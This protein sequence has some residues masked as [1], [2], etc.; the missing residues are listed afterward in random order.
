MR[1]CFLLAL[2]F[3]LTVGV[4]AR[5]A[6]GENCGLTSL[7]AD[8]RIAAC[9]Q[10]IA[11]GQG[12]TR[13]MVEALT[14]RAFL[15]RI[16]GDYDQAIADLTEAL[17]LSP[18][19]AMAY[20]YRGLSWNS[21]GDH[22]RAIADYTEAI[23]I[24]ANYAQAYVN[25]GAARSGKGDYDGAIADHSEA[26]RLNPP[27][28]GAYVARAYAWTHKGDKDKAIA[29][30]GEAIRIDPKYEAAYMG[31]GEMWRASGDY[32]RSMAD[33]EAVL[34]I[35]PESAG[36]YNDIAWLRATAM[37]PKF[38]DARQAV[39]SAKKACRLSEW[40]RASHLDTLAAAYAE[41]GDFDQA[42]RWEEKALTFS[43]NSG[44]AGEKMRERLARYRQKKPYRE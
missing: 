24:N 29:D 31:R 8:D 17:R 42:V 5:S 44:S 30:Y 25:R 41:A 43:A 16:S 39:E 38:R 14:N 2:Q 19:N 7:S 12:S 27:Y 6:P 34:R 1:L 33:F 15:L 35:R 13:E 28:T 26:I 36:A 3:V 10:F 11:S 23:R 20:H 21:K 37:D 40:K 32:A 18:R 4:Y 22:D 9:T